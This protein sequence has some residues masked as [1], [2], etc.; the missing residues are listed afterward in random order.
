MDPAVLATLLRICDAVSAT[1]LL[2]PFMA[3]VREGDGETFAPEFADSG[4]TVC[5]ICHCRVSDLARLDC[6][7]GCAS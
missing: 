2:A 1:R 7:S 6:N 4:F 5:H 3:I